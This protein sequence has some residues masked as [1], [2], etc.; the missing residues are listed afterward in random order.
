MNKDIKHTGGYGWQGDFEASMSDDG[1]WSA[2]VSYVAPPGEKF[3][4]PYTLHCHVPG[5]TDLTLSGYE[6]SQVADLW[7][8]TCTFKKDAPQEEDD[9]DNPDNP[10]EPDP[11]EFDPKDTKTTWEFTAGVTSKSI[12]DHPDFKPMFQNNPDLQKA[13][14]AIMSGRVDLESLKIG[15][16]LKRKDPYDFGLGGVKYPKELSDIF[17]KIVNKGITD[18]YKKSCSYSITTTEGKGPDN[19]LLSLIEAA[20]GSGSFTK[21]GEDNN[22]YGRKTETTKS[23]SQILEEGILLL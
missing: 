8:T 4:P 7:K 10:D 14:E 12:F 19:A 9:P 21:M 6:H 15:A 11:W 18:Y 13:Y 5:F 22:P 17:N 23:F 2:S 3:T 20:G 16:K 1:S